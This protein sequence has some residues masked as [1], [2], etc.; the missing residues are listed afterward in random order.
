M[1]QQDRVALT[2]V[3]VCNLFLRLL[4]N[5]FVADVWDPQA[6]FAAGAWEA[7]E[8]DRW[9]P[10]AT[11][12]KF[13]SRWLSVLGFTFAYASLPEQHSVTMPQIS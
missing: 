2:G 4:P 6:G 1:L 5:R 3:L 7:E 11:G 13:R 12:M 10:L 8:L 9:C